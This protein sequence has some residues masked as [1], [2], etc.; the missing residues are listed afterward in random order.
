MKKN[1]GK[2]WKEEVQKGGVGHKEGQKEIGRAQGKM[3]GR[4]SWNTQR[5]KERWKYIYLL[6]FIKEENTKKQIE[7]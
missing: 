5:R 7:Q 4:R 6:P 2:G 3:Y 1:K